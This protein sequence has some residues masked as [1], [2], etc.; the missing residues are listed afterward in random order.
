M[1]IKERNARDMVCPMAMAHPGESHLG[2]RGKDCMAW[3][4]EEKKPRSHFY[5]PYQDGF[6]EYPLLVDEP[7]RPENVPANWLWQPADLDEG[8][9]GYWDEP[10][11]EAKARA[12]GFCLM[13]YKRGHLSIEG[14]V[15]TCPGD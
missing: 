5:A 11:D 4:W 7:N 3:E 15:T 12:T 2:C 9:R 13:A 8:S 10:K 1:I 6:G 14:C